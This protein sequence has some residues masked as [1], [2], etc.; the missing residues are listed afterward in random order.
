MNDGYSAFELTGGS[1]G[2]DLRNNVVWLNG[3]GVAVYDI[4]EGSSAKTKDRNCYWNEAAT[5]KPVGDKDVVADPR[6]MDRERGDLRLRA[7]SP[8]IDAV[9]KLTGFQD[10]LAGTPRP[11]G[12]GWDIGAYERG[13]GR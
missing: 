8:C 12:K 10:D 5:L 11:A 1:T 7:D 2:A 3:K 4:N 6:F 13:P 9:A